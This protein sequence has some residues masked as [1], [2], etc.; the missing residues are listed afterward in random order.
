MLLR[1]LNRP[2][3]LA[4]T[5]KRHKASNS[6]RNW[7]LTLERTVFHIHVYRYATKKC[8]GV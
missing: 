4:L 1:T 5:T 3:V 8:Y 2:T 7:P 6:I